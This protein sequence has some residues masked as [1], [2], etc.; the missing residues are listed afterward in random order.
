MA[1]VYRGAALTLS[2]SYASADSEGFL[3]HRPLLHSTVK[4]T[5]SSGQSAEIYLADRSQLMENWPWAGPECNVI[6]PLDTRGWCLQ[7]CYLSNRQLKFLNT[8]ILWS[9]RDM[10]F[11]EGMSD[12]LEGALVIRGTGKHFTYLFRGIQKPRH[13]SMSLLTPY[14]SWYNMVSEFSRRSLTFASDVLPALSGLAYEVAIH[15]NGK[16][17][18]GVWWEDIAFGLCWKKSETLKPASGSNGYIAPSWSWAS[19]IGPVEF[20]NSKDVMYQHTP[21]TVPTQV[22]FHD[23]W[24]QNPGSNPYGQVDDACIKLDAPFISLQGKNKN[25]LCIPA[26]VSSGGRIEITFDFEEDKQRDN[27]SALFLLR[28][29]PHIIT[30]DNEEVM[31]FGLVICPVSSPSQNYGHLEVEVTTRFYERVGFIQIWISLNEE[32]KYWETPNNFIILV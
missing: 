31:L 25:T 27:L 11:D 21:I 10:D 12:R 29:L 8:K 19:V 9:C 3:K 16:Y 24:I 1:Q 5:S 18:A 17:C 22:L 15:D 30:S 13:R 14:S 23:F 7:E 32:C 2:A 4:I 28:R 26:I 20:V 6:P